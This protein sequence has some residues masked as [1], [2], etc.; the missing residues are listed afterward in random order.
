MLNPAGTADAGIS[1]AGAESGSTGITVASTSKTETAPANISAGGSSV[2]VC[3][4][5]DASV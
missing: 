5:S 3:P 2:I 4:S 1:A